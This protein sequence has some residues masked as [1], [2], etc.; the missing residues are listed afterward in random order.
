VV[1]DEPLYLL[2]LWRT[3]H[4]LNT[5]LFE[6]QREMDAVEATIEVDAMDLDVLSRLSRLGASEIHEFL[7]FCLTNE[8]GVLDPEVGLETSLDDD[9]S[10]VVFLGSLWL[11]GVYAGVALAHE[12]SNNT[13]PKP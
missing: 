3:H 8:T 10:I 1:S 12:S 2:C 7:E 4:E 11:G 5:Q 13:D 6:R 9:L